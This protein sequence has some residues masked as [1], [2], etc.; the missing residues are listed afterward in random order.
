MLHK[1]LWLINPV[2]VIKS[3][4][5][6]FLFNYD[7]YTDIMFYEGCYGEIEIGGNEIR[8]QMILLPSLVIPILIEIIMTIGCCKCCSCVKTENSCSR[9]NF[10]NLLAKQLVQDKCLNLPAQCK[11]IMKYYHEQ[12]KTSI[13]RKLKFIILEDAVQI[14]VQVSVSN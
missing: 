13:N 14:M 1:V 4:L 7:I 11:E 5:T 6:T 10:I 9:L 8:A 12:A 3:I 2:I